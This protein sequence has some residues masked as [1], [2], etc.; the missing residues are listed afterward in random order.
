MKKFLL[1][2]LSVLYCPA[3]F[4]GLFVLAL[5]TTPGTAL[6]YFGYPALAVLYFLLAGPPLKRAGIGRWALWLW[7]NL[8][9][10]PLCWA[11]LTLLVPGL[12]FNAGILLVLLPVTAILTAVWCLT[13]LGFLVAKLLRTPPK[14][15]LR[16]AKGG[17]ASVWAIAKPVL[18]AAA[19]AGLLV[20][21]RGYLSVR[22]AGDYADKGVMTFTAASCY[23]TSVKTTGS[24]GRQ[25]TRTAYI[26]TYKAGGTGYSWTQEAATNSAGQ[27]AVK[28]KRQV[29]RRVLSIPEEGKYIT[30]EPR[31]TAE[32]YVGTTRTKYLCLFGVSAGYL[33][34]WAVWLIWR[35]RGREP[36]LS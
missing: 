17:L 31:Y 21:G 8:L 23:P 12:W 20:G 13:G 15:L 18:F 36:S 34:L 26:V 24:R 19:A 29:Q 33:A 28:E 5:R 16:G 4:L 7:M 30:V 9:G 27:Q 22:P 14:Q 3:V 10:Y 2:L 1:A 11:A 32:S 25:N 35:Q 6:L